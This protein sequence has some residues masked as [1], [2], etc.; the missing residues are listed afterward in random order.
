MRKMP[1]LAWWELHCVSDDFAGR[2]PTLQADVLLLQTDVLLL[3]ADVLLCWLVRVVLVRTC[4][5]YN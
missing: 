1:D 3:Q 5:H 2:C 4:R